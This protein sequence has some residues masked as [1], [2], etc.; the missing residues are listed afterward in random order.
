MPGTLSQCASRT[1]SQSRVQ[2]PT[3]A[4][5]VHAP[6]DRRA[7]RCTFL[8]ERYGQPFAIGDAQSLLRC[9][10]SASLPSMHA[11]TLPGTP[12]TVPTER[13]HKLHLSGAQ[14]RVQ[15]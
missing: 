1:M 7:D 10:G 11:H 5:S 8:L 15:S 2:V 9:P 4:H 3:L 6:V 14:S 13:A 12:D